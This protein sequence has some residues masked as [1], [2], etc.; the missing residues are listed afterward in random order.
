MD[1]KQFK[2]IN[3]YNRRSNDKS[4]FIITGPKEKLDLNTFKR[5]DFY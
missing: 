1:R 4:A 5:S 3:W 2:E